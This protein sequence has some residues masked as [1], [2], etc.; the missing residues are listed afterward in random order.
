MF[1]L[2]E[3]WNRLDE[4]NAVIYYCFEDLRSG[5]YCV[6]NAEFFCLPLSDRRQQADRQAV[7]LFIEECPST[8][9]EWAQ[10]LEAAISLHDA[11]FES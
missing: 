2:H 8:R 4:Q 10:T 7:E 1:K 6:Q 5:Q 3:V 9:G 11:A